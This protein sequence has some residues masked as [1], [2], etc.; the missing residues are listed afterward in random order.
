MNTPKEVRMNRL[1]LRERERFGSRIDAD[2]DMHTENRLFM[3]WALAY[4]DRSTG[5]RNKGMDRAFL[6]QRSDNFVEIGH[7]QNLDETVERVRTLIT[8]PAKA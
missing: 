4:E 8:N 3:D 1:E 6:I 5:S 2:G 7:T